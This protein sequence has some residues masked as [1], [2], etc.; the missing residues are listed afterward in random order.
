MRTLVGPSGPVIGA[1]ARLHRQKGIIYLLRAAPAVLARFPEA[2]FAVAGGGPLERDLRLEIER[3][4]LSGRFLLLGERADAAD[5]TALADVFVL[6]SLWE[7]LPL[8]LLE[9]AALGKPIAATDIDG[10]REVVR[11]GETA[12]L[13]PAG[14]PARL[15]DAV[16]RLIADRPSPRDW[17]RAARAGSRRGS[18]WR[19]W[20][21]PSRTSISS[22][23]PAKECHE[24]RPPRP[25]PPARPRP[26]SC[27][28]PRRAPVAAQARPPAPERPRGARESTPSA[29]PSRPGPR[30]SWPTRSRARSPSTTRSSSPARPGCARRRSS[31]TRSIETQT[32]HDLVRGYGIGTVRIDRFKGAADATST[33][34]GPGELWMLKPEKRLIARLE[35]DPALVSRGSADVDVTGAA[36]LRPAAHGRGGQSPGD[37]GPQDR[38]TRTRSPSC[39]RT[40][41]DRRQALDA[42]GAGASSPS[43]PRTVS[44]PRPGHLQRGGYAGLKSLQFGMTV[45]WRQWSELLEDVERRHDRDAAPCRTKLREVSRPLRGR[46]R[47]DPR[48]GARQEGRH[49]HRAP[50]RGLPQARRQRRHERVV[51]PARDPPGPLQADRAG[52]PAPARAGRSTSSGPTRSPGPT[53]SSSRIPAW[54]RRS[55]VNINMDM[56][57]EALRKNNSWL[58]MS[59]CPDH[60]P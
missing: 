7:G 43:P 47:L 45:S 23:P 32:L 52:R 34:P 50:F 15:A 40:P 25:H 19:P 5:L 10:V 14:D 9:A 27:S 44:R 57:G 29:R 24:T 38:S 53:S 41:T 2:K 56:V 37:G 21:A 12:L 59:E 46:P 48:Q 18:P 20:P 33:T 54:P 3:L 4:G 36:R 1:V 51:G 28:H 39:G 30:A 16:I 8:V 6:P 22:S 26:R 55:T 17:G 42:A 31:R 49:L 11:D 13:V 58:T 60:L 35:A